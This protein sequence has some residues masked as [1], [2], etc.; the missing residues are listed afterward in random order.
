VRHGETENNFKKL[1][2]GKEDKLTKLGKEQAKKLALRLKDKKFDIIFCSSLKRTRETAKEI[3]EFHKKTPVIYSED[4]RERDIG[5][6]EGTPWSKEDDSP[7]IYATHKPK[8]GESRLEFLERVRKFLD[9]LNK[10]Y[11]GKEVLLI[12]HGGVSRMFNNIVNNKL[13]G[14]EDVNWAQDNCCVNILEF[15]NDKPKFKLY[16]CTKHLR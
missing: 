1:Y 8:G 10:N 15:E 9:Y 12:S 16:N 3:L 11:K 7:E 13:P 14:F 2:Q 5:E 6:L 4:I